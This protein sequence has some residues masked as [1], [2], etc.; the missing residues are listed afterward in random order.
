MPQ[1]IVRTE[2]HAL[3]FERLFRPTASVPMLLLA[4]SGLESSGAQECVMMCMTG[5]LGVLH[6]LNLLRRLSVRDNMYIFVHM[7][8]DPVGAFRLCG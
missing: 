2:L 6:G 8:L 7:M 5:D 3:R 4:V 1:K